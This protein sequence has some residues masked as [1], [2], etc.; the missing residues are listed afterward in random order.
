VTASGVA[1]VFNPLAGVGPSATEKV[2]R[3]WHVESRPEEQTAAL[4]IPADPVPVAE[5]GGVV[6]SEKNA[7][8]EVP[9]DPPAAEPIVIPEEPIETKPLVPCEER[10]K[11]QADDAG[12]GV[13]PVLAQSTGFGP[14]ALAEGVMVPE[15]TCP[16]LMPYCTDEDQAPKTMPYATDSEE[17]PVL[18]TGDDGCCNADAFWKMFLG[19][20]MPGKDP[21]KSPMPEPVQPKKASGC[22]EDPNYYDHYS[23]CPFT[24]CPFTGRS[25]PPSDAPKHVGSQ[26]ES[27]PKTSPKKKPT[28]TLPHSD[29]D[30]DC[31]PKKH[32]DI[33]TME[34]RPSDGKLNEFRLG[35][36]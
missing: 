24:T 20:E 36:S 4:S 13:V 22:Q 1:V 35:P 33:D 8:V 14:D 15:N 9:A 16:R 28:K 2:L 29:W 26:E 30:D 7:L 5:E 18:E 19:Y 17:E 6:V 21:K 31:C 3:P 23:G 25:Y 34:Y 27:E 32:L 10:P 12:K 11:P